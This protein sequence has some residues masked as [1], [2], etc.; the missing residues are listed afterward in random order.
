MSAPP[1]VKATFQA[2]LINAGSNVLAQGI[3]AYRDQRPF[4]LDV[5]TLLQF[6]TCAVIISPLTFLWL[7]NLESAFPGFSDAAKSKPKAEKGDARASDD[8]RTDK[9]K[10][11]LNVRNTVIKVVID[12]TIGAAWNTVLFLTTMGILRGQDYDTVLEAIRKDFWPIMIAGF[13]M[14]PL[15]SILCFTV[16]P[17]DKRLL[18]TSLFGVL[19]AIYLSLVSN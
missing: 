18:V 8:K 9:K 13:K 11:Q 19:W 2:A 15:V 3:K 6:T 12:Q 16:V 7:E 1:I 5:R 17:A 14:W 4:E 10:P